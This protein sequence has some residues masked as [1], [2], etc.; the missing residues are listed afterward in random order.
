LIPEASPYRKRQEPIVCLG[1][2]LSL[3]FLIRCH[4]VIPS[5]HPA[6]LAISVL[7]IDRDIPQITA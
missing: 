2:L 3:R 1:P 6:V 5:P 7:D 4:E